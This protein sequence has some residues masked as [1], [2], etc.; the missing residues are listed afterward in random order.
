MSILQYRGINLQVSQLLKGTERKPIYDGPQYLYTRWR[1]ICR[2]L[3]NPQATSYNFP[4]V[5]EAGG[6]PIVSPNLPAQTDQAIRHR[7][8]N[9]R[10][11][12]ILGV[13]T[14]AWLVSP[15]QGFTID[16]ANGPTPLFCNVVRGPGGRSFIVDY[17]IETCLREC[18]LEVAKYPSIFLSHRWTMRH[19]IDDDFF[20]TRLID[21]HVIFDTARLAQG[22]VNP[23]DYRSTLFHLVPDDFQRTSVAVEANAD[24]TSVDYSITDEELEINIGEDAKAAGVTRIE[25]SHSAS[26]TQVGTSKIVYEAV[27]TAASV[28][29]GILA[30]SAAGGAL[31]QRAAPKG[32]ALRRMSV[33]ARHGLPGQMAAQV[34]SGRI[35]GGIYGGLSATFSGAEALAHYLPTT[36]HKI[37]A[38]VW[39]RPDSSKKSLE[40]VA[41]QIC[42]DRISRLQFVG[43]FFLMGMENTVEWDLAGR[44][45]QASASGVTVAFSAEDL[46]SGGD[47]V[48]WPLMP[49]IQN[50]GGIIV[51]EVLTTFART[52][53]EVGKGFS[54]NNRSKYMEHIVTQALTEPCQPQPLPRGQM[55]V[56][57]PTKNPTQASP[58]PF[59][60]T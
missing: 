47:F 31:A 3:Y 22:Q 44:Y 20:T 23:D 15:Q 9:P 25:A 32:Q 1:I 48:D 10:G 56:D 4:V 7:L 17:G 37:V 46:H 33:R 27:K 35:R 55:P 41:V 43:V 39:G 59:V 36:V 38:G 6:G 29:G 58:L 8:F 57:E 12:L 34:R 2:C 28:V 16:S 50:V 19:E 45:V 52:N 18:N 14:V 26:L 30:G 11:Q 40:K 42:N 60:F 54:F 13:G 21:G 24:G 49:Q 53:P 5:G 51:D